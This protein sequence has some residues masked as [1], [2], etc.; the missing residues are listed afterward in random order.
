[1]VT[2]G[3]LENTPVGRIWVAASDDGL[4]GINL[5]DEPE[6]FLTGIARMTSEIPD[7]NAQ[8]NAIVKAAIAELEAYLRGELD[9]FTVPIEWAILK[10]FHREV[11]EQVMAVPYGHTTSY[12]AIAERIGRP[13]AVRAVG[14]ANATNPIP[15]II[16]CHRILGADGKLHGYGARGGLETKA[17][18][19]RLEG[20]WLI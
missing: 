18:L 7:P 17:W 4:V 12:G 14:R 9:E 16:P 19:L 5:W 3:K 11:L 6:R 10:P 2:I 20:S 13:G 15:I 8:P 1:M